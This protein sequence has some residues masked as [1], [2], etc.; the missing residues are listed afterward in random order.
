MRSALAAVILTL[1]FAS[2]AAADIP[3]TLRVCGDASEWPPFTYFERR[4][5]IRTGNPTGFSVEYIRALAALGGRAAEV[6]LLPWQRCLYL[7]DQG[8]YDV[9]LDGLQG[10]DRVRDFLYTEPAYTIRF[11]GLYVTPAGPEAAGNAADPLNGRVCGIRAYDYAAFGVPLDRIV[12][13]APTLEAAIQLLEA[14]R[15]DVLPTSLEVLGGLPLTGGPNILAD[16]RFA[17]RDLSERSRLNFFFIVNRSLSYAQELV[18]TLDRGMEE[19]KQSGA[20]A[21]IAARFLASGR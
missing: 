13:R 1:L 6:D 20:R 21:S 8:Q 12:A 2:G 19:M 3:K 15:C 17:W 4:D 7:A 18:D 5:G 16:P 14:G 11:V 10:P 9:L